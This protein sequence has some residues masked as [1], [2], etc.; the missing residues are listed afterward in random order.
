MNKKLNFFKDFTL[1]DVLNS[2]N[3]KFL[4]DMSKDEEE[5]F[6]CQIE[7]DKAEQNDVGIFDGKNCMRCLSSKD[8][9]KLIDHN[10]FKVIK[11]DPSSD[12]NV[13]VVLTFYSLKPY[14]FI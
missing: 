1:G 11:T 8:I 10:V 12:Y 3:E 2:I 4:V 5:Y 6:L 14:S 13:G 9:V 7:I